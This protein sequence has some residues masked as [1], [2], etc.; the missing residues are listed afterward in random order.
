MRLDDLV[1]RHDTVDHR[2]ELTRREEW[3][4]LT[5]EALRRIGLLRDRARAKHS[6]ANEQSLSQNE[7]ERKIHRCPTHRPHDDDPAL[8]RGGTDTCDK[9]VAAHQFERYV[10]AAP[11]RPSLDRRLKRRQIVP[12]DDTIDEAQRPGW[13]NLVM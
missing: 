3:D 11:R 12:E 8:W 6:T 2:S 5:S 7:A 13:S 9:V 1:E 10:D 4:D